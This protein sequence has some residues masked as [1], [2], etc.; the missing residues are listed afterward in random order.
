M[1]YRRAEGAVGGSPTAA[2]MIGL[3]SAR[4]EPQRAAK[5]RTLGCSFRRRGKILVKRRITA[6]FRLGQTD[7]IQL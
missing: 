3:D 1:A 4:G 2:R 5:K 7:C 6:R